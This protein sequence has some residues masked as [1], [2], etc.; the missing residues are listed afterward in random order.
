MT[1]NMTRDDWQLLIVMFLE[2]KTLEKNMTTNM[3]ASHVLAWYFE[4]V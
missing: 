1:E 3:T 4:D 2:P